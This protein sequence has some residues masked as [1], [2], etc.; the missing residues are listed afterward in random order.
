MEQF[1]RCGMSIALNCQWLSPAALYLGGGATSGEADD[2]LRGA[3]K[4]QDG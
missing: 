1:T 2:N 4:M 3:T